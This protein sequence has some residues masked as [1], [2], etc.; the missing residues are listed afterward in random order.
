MVSGNEKAD[1]LASRA[2]FTGILKMGRGEKMQEV[3]D[4][5]LIDDTV[6]EET[7]LLRL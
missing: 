5:L 1:S 6:V 2:Q 7:A 4:S 3:S